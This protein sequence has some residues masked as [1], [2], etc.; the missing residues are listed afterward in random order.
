MKLTPI[1]IEDSTRFKIGDIVEINSDAQWA[2]DWRNT[3]CEVIG[4][5]WDQRVGQFNITLR[6]D[7]DQITD[8]F[9]IDDLSRALSETR[10]G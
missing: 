6:H 1:Q 8:D 2:G 4:I 9:R 3:T 10:E 5:Y 7:G